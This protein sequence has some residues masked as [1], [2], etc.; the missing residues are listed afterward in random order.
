MKT[1]GDDVNGHSHKSGYSL[2]ESCLT[3]SDAL[4]AA[5]ELT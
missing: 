1:N 3:K 2:T 5:N 4:L